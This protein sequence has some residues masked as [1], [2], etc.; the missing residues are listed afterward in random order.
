M[1]KYA[2]ARVST[3]MRVCAIALLGIFQSVALAVDGSI[4]EGIDYARI[5]PAQPTRVDDDKIEVL[6]VFWYGCPHCYD[7]EPH[8][9]KWLENKPADVEFRR[10]PG[11]LNPGWSVHAAAYYVAEQLGVLD[12]IH[13]PL[14]E[15]MHNHV[16]DYQTVDSMAG[17][18]AKHGVSRDQYMSA[19][20]SFA[21]R[22]KVRHAEQ[23]EKRYGVSGV[24][25]V[26]VAG[27]YRTSAT[28]AGG[29]FE[30]LLKV[31]NFLV[32]KERNERKQG[33][34]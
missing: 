4:D 22:A 7:F 15:A 26:I 19:Y 21:V 10:M 16:R 17:F 18:F 33:K 8:L 13:T 1:T 5:V 25:T 24:P 9:H 2:R 11:Q 6:E 3:W 29:S 23:Q 30:A 27:K 31:V 12:K 32:D 28:M 20:N 34:S 14:F